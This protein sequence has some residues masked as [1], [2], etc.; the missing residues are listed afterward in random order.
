MYRAWRL[1]RITQ[2]EAAETLGVSD[3]TF[4]RWALRYEALGPEGL[5]DR[6]SLGGSH[7]RAPEAEVAALEALYNAEYAGSSVRHFWMRYREVHGGKRSYTWVKNRLQIAGLVER[8][9]RKTPHRKCRPRKPLEGLV[10]HQD[11]SRRPWLGDWMHD[12]VITMDDATSHVYS[13]FFVEQE[14][15]WSS[16]R[17]VAETIAAKGIF[18]SLRTDRRSHYWRTPKTGGKVDSKRLT[19]FGRAMR[20]LGIE[21]IP[22]YAPQ[23][24]GRCA[25]GFRALEERL[26]RDLAHQGIREVEA[27]NAYLRE[28]WPRFNA[29]FGVRAQQ[30]GGAFVPLLRVNLNEILCLKQTQIVRDDNC[31]TYRGTVLRIP[32]QRHRVDF[33]REE[34]EVREY[35]DGQLAVFHNGLRLGRYHPDGR[36][37]EARGSVRKAV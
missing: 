12:L 32:L 16:F 33:A 11:A 2:A 4:R 1:R 30:S 26:P 15:T 17:G 7:R 27:A 35:E 31:L 3:R 10:V 24:G 9:C 20:E 25:R 28:Y 19:Q 34:V 21:M 37:N 5:R 23:A 8:H 22:S 36:P 29:A 13:G 18:A 6:R 14:G